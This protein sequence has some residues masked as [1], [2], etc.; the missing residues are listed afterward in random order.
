MLL[1]QAASAEDAPPPSFVT[2]CQVCHILDRVVVGPSL[3][4]LADLYPKKDKASF[5]KWC[6]EPGKK[7]PQM[8]AMPSMAHIPEK[9]L[10]AIHDYILKVTV[11]VEKVRPSQV[12]PY[13]S[14]PATTRRPRVIRTFVPESSPSS[15][16]IALP[17]PDK[18]NL[19]W[20]TDQCRLRYISEGEPDNYPYLR[21]NGNSLAKVGD[22]IY[23]EVAPVFPSDATQFKGMRLSKDGFPSLIYTVNGTEITESISV[24]GQR[25]TRTFSSSGKLPGHQ[26]PEPNGRKIK[27]SVKPTADQLIITHA[28]K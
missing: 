8:P 6:I 10:E 7:R 16:I 23:R 14:A 15:M 19:I 21:S 13:A 5:V 11:G 12:D 2:N 4:E 26:Q 17:T 22:I 27:T 20:D 18:L 9:E 3:V 1:A 25:V 28:P 24:D